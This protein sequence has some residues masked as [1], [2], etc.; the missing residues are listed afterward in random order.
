MMQSLRMSALAATALLTLGAPTTARATEHKPAGC[1]DRTPHAIRKVQV[2]PGV[3]LEILDWGGSGKAMVMLSGGGDNAHVYDQ[4][5]FQFTDYFHVIGIT[6]RG[7]LPSSQPPSGYDVPTRAADDIAVLDALGI[8]KAVFAGHS[9]A[10]AELSE[11]G[12]KHAARVEKLVY[13]DAADLAE[14]FLPSRRE[15]P[16]PDYTDADLKSLQAYQAA[17]ARLQALRTPA[18]AVCHGLR[19]AADGRILDS[20]TPDGVPA[21]ISASVSSRPPT[22]WAKIKVPRLGIFAIFTR[23]ARQA[24][25]WYLSPAKQAKFDKAWGPIVDWH[26]R[27]IRRFQEG[28]SANTFLLPGAPHYVYINNEAEVVRWVRKFLGIPPRS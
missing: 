19:F 3:E 22:D 28:N 10:G 9:A 8:D 12:A 16:L 15:P 23:E 4:F 6:R 17:M 13:L 11:L 2:A 5:A 26:R 1:E 25:Y 27:T 7:Y 24:W 18:P 20:T 14:R 21:K